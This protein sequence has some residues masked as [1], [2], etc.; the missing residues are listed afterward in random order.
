[1]DIYCLTIF[2]F[3]SEI[4]GPLTQRL[5]SALLNV[6]EIENIEHKLN[7]DTEKYLRKE[8]ITLGIMD[9]DDFPKVLN[10]ME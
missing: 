6:P 3:N 1:M 7:S 9:E 8:L 4:P 10:S 2:L 5:L